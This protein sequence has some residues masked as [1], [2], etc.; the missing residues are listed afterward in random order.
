MAPFVILIVVTLV[1]WLAGRLG[2]RWLRPWTAPLRGGLAAMFT[3]T[4][5]AHFIGLRAELI[6]MVPPWLPAPE[7]LVTVTGVLELAGVVGLLWTPT[8]RWAAGALTVLLLVMFP[9]NVYAALNGL[10]LSVFDQLWSRTALQIVFLAATIAVFLGLRCRG[11]V[12]YSR[13]SQG[14]SP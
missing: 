7:F 3:A 2:V 12:L 11:A 10:S 4:G 14:G 8:A 6:A 9:A 5:L 13:V 1:L